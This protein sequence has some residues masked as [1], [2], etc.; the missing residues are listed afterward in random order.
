MTPLRG[1]CGVIERIE[2]FAQR[3]HVARK[4]MLQIS[5]RFLGQLEPA[6]IGAQ[7]QRLDLFLVIELAHRK[8][9]GRRQAR[10]QV[11]EAE[12]ESARGSRAP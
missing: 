2:D 11:R 3:A 12:R 1:E 6:Q 7:V 8:H 10:L 5:R 4:A 9:R